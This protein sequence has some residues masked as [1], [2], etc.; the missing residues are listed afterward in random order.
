MDYNRI[1]KLGSVLSKDYAQEF[2]RILVFYQDI[3]ASEAASKLELHIKTAQ[4]F[5]E[6]LCWLNIVERKEVSENKRPY[7]R[8]SLKQRKIYL[9]I[10][11][12]KLFNLEVTKYKLDQKIRER[13]NTGAVF[14]SPA[15]SN[16]ISTISIFFGKGRERSEKKI[17]LTKNQGK[18][19]FHLPFPNAEFMRISDIMQKA[20]VDRSL[21]LE[22]LDIV[23]TLRDTKVIE[24]L[25]ENH[26]TN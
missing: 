17:R 12:Q 13:T 19:I 16:Y 26:E 5:L 18:F 14:T 10:D 11:L 9:E 20:E 25:D 8:Y 22:V 1:A 4:D 7:F 2:F 3:S 21:T 15:K 23:E 6:E 24:F